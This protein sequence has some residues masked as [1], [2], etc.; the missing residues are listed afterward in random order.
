MESE[1]T[2]KPVWP[3]LESQIWREDDV[4]A[5]A[6]WIDG[7]EAWKIP[8]SNHKGDIADEVS[9][10]HTT[11]PN[12][13][14]I[15]DLDYL[16]AAADKAWTEY[17]GLYL[18]GQPSMPWINEDMAYRKWRAEDKRRRELEAEQALLQA[19]IETDPVPTANGN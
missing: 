4:G 12:E 9:R 5:L 14:P 13:R 18:T 16:L 11:F 6:R 15:F 8:V 2:P 10:L 19:V 17:R 3:W 7:R 1:K